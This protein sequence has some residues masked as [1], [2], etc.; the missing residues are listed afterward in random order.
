MSAWLDHHPDLD[1]VA[2]AIASEIRTGRFGPYL[3]YDGK[4][5]R[6]PKSVHAKAATMTYEECMAYIKK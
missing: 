1:R 6:L 4:N 2:D 3:T 5:Y